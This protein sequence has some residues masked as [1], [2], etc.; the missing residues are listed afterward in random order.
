MM[1]RVVITH[2]NGVEHVSQGPAVTL[3]E[4][5]KRVEW[6]AQETARVELNGGTR[7]EDISIRPV[8]VRCPPQRRPQSL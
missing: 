5:L 8:M 7:V 1:Y 6:W 2:S 4:A 3:D